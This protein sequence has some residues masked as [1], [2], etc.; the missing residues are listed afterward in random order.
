MIKSC[1]NCALKNAEWCRCSE[2]VVP[3]DKKG[4]CIDWEAKTI[5]DEFRN[6]Y[7][8]ENYKGKHLIKKTKSIKKMPTIE[9]FYNV[10]YN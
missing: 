4:N 6:K 8:S 5:W 2:F 1:S 7:N 9:M 3:R 10:E